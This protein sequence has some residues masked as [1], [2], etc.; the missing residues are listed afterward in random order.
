MVGNVAVLTKERSNM[1]EEDEKLLFVCI[2]EKQLAGD[3][4]NK[5]IIREKSRQL[6]SDFLKKKEL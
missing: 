4:V 2:N 1:V 5:P 3:N 6:N